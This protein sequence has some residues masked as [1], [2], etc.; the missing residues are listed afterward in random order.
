MRKTRN[1]NEKTCRA[2]K[3][4]GRKEKG[5]TPSAGFGD[6]IL[7]RREKE[8]ERKRGGG[9][10]GEDIIESKILLRQRMHRV[11]PAGD[12]ACG[13]STKTRAADQL[14]REIYGTDDGGENVTLFRLRIIPPLAP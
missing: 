2:Q 10:E 9:G 7:R 3:K 12:Y 13:I 11:A 8:R 5:K 4:R 14:I 1:A 6:K